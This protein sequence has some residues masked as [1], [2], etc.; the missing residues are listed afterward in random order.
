MLE[1]SF[2]LS[3]L[4]MRIKPPQPTYLDDGEGLLARARE[5][6]QKQTETTQNKK[7]TR[8]MLVSLLRACSKLP[9]SSLRPVKSN[10]RD[11]S[12]GT[13]GLASTLGARL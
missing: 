12:I 7:E 1:S 8:K 2:L 11:I 6:Q 13:A 10:P 4:Q 5:H 9:R 3:P